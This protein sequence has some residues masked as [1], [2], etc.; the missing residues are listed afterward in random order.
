MASLATV[1]ILFCDLV[2]ST[3]LLVRVGDPAGDEV[4]RSCF[5]AWRTAVAEHHGV[6]VKS[7]GDGL[8]VSFASAVDAVECAAALQGATHRL[9][10][11]RPGLGLA[12]RVGISAGEAA[13]DEGDW[14]GTPV[15]EAAR[16]CA[17]AAA[18]EI[19]ASEIVAILVRH[20]SDRGF[21]DAGAYVLK[22]LPAPV[23]AVSFEWDREPA[24]SIA[25][26]RPLAR[27]ESLFAFFV[28]REDDL[29]RLLRGW[30]QVVAGEPQC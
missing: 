24:P 19:L 17:A 25:L 22:G 2:G 21:R 15:V 4:R 14:F 18:G 29:E 11:Q 5:S 26:P 30:K 28:G 6:E 7:Q 23:P 3:D 13:A 1:S 9:D 8:M 16:L 27:A 10:R 20:R 12:L